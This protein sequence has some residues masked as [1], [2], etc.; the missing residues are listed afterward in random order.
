MRPS[1]QLF[2]LVEKHVNENVLGYDFSRF[3]IY[4]DH[5]EDDLVANLNH[6]DDVGITFAHNQ[7]L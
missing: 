1:D 2:L 6:K 4:H 3:F 7:F 5:D